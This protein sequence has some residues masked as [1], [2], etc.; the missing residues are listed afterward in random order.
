M[1]QRVSVLALIGALA[2]SVSAAQAAP[3]G[4]TIV[5]METDFGPVHLELFDHITPLTVQNFL[6]YVNFEWDGD[7]FSVYDGALFHRLIHDFVLQGGGFYFIDGHGA[8]EVPKLD[9]VPNEPYLSNVRGTVAMAKLGGDPDSATNQFFFNLGDNSE[10]LDFQNGGFTVFARV[11]G[12]DMDVIDVIASLDT[13]NASNVHPAFTDIPLIEDDGSLFV[14]GSWVVKVVEDYFDLNESGSVNF[15]DVD[16]LFA[17]IIGGS[18]DPRFDL[19]R[20]GVIDID[21]VDFLLNSGMGKLRGDLTGDGRI[22]LRDAFILMEN[23]G[24]QSAGYAQGDLIGDGTV[25]DLDL[26]V[27]QAALDGG[28]PAATSVPEPASLTLLAMGGLALLRRRGVR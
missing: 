13:F 22:G 21:D 1:R 25:G 4:N 3:G 19:N 11:I 17:A 5:R 15:D 7:V 27:I 23:F 12:N 28:G 26:A 6:S 16:A 10:N 24:P 18:M 20:D 14:T 9:P 8:V 2:V